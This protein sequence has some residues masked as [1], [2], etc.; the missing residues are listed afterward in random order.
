MV[1]LI[2]T[3]SGLEDIRPR[4]DVLRDAI[5]V[6]TGVLS[7]AEIAELRASGWNLT[8]FANPLDVND[9]GSNIATMREHHPDQVM[10]IE[11]T[12]G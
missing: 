3:R 9:L 7:Q 8:D 5:W 4:I 2:L 1:I 11:A 12:P 10:W 6:N